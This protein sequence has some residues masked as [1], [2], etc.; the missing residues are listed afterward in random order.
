MGTNYIMLIF[1]GPGQEASVSF[2]VFIAL[3]RIRAGYNDSESE[4]Q[5][6]TL[7]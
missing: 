5:P 4:E 6:L 2:S 3:G 1:D 7:S